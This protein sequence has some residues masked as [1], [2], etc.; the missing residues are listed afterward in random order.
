MTSNQ[1]S[2]KTTFQTDARQLLIYKISSPTT[3]WF[4]SL[5]A[6]GLLSMIGFN[7]VREGFNADG[8]TG[9]PAYYSRIFLFYGLNEKSTY[10]SPYLDGF[11]PWIF[12]PFLG[13]WLGLALFY[14]KHAGF[15]KNG[16]T[17]LDSDGTLSFAFFGENVFGFGINI[18]GVKGN[19]FYIGILW[20]PIISASIITAVYT[21]HVKRDTSIVTRF[22]F[23]FVIALWTGIQIAKMTDPNLSFSLQ[24]AY[25][26]L[27][28][29]RKFNTFIVFDG[30][31]HPTLLA[32]IFT[33]FQ[34]IPMII[35]GFISSLGN[36]YRNTK[37]SMER[38]QIRREM[39]AKRK[40]D[41]YSKLPW[42]RGNKEGE[43]KSDSQK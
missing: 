28:L 1:S 24:G 36:I 9:G 14:L 19:L 34:I 15:S 38:Y 8:L 20:F 7:L 13:I 29:D 21:K 27:F 22:F 39:H 10:D 26:S 32:F 11:L 41:G 43:P 6:T 17:F 23:N 33:L 5:W 16:G 25:E 30:E 3:V 18:F 2:S 4:F 42:E 31:Y 40:R 37:A 35:F 12:A